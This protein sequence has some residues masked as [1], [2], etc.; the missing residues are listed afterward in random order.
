MIASCEQAA[1]DVDLVGGQE[2]REETSTS[3]HRLA[4]RG[5]RRSLHRLFDVNVRMIPGKNLTHLSDVLQEVFVQGMSNLQ[6]PDE[7]EGGNFTPQM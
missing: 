1:P 4:S 5:G 7:C 3:L 2:L 6:S